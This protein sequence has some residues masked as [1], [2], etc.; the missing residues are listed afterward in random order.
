LRV[1]KTICDLPF[2]VGSPGDWVSI[3]HTTSANSDRHHRMIDCIWMIRRAQT[4]G[5][6]NSN[7]TAG[8]VYDGVVSKRRPIALSLRPLARLVR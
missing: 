5:V 3:R 1:A 7:V 2:F 6:S 8:S 4:L